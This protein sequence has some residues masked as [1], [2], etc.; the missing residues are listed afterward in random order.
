MQI[1]SI[2]YCYF[3]EQE[4]ETKTNNLKFISLQLHKS[5][6]KCLKKPEEG[7]S[8]FRNLRA[9]DKEY[10]YLKGKEDTMYNWGVGV[11]NHLSMRPKRRNPQRVP[12]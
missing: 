1:L 12:H 11:G 3:Q 8:W 2:L 6:N 9:K 5:S 7:Y 10:I 4:R